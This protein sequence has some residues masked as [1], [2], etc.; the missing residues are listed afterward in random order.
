MQVHIVISDTDSSIQKNLAQDVIN[1]VYGRGVQIKK[2]A[3]ED[4]PAVGGGVPPAPLADSPSPQ[5][6]SDGS[7]GSAS[8]GGLTLSETAGIPRELVNPAVA[9]GPANVPGGS[10][11]LDKEGLPWDARIHSDS[12][13]MNADGTWR[14]RRN[15]EKSGVD[16]AAIEAELRAIVGTTH[17]QSGGLTQ[18]QRSQYHVPGVSAEAAAAIQAGLPVM[19][20][21]QAAA[22]LAAES[23]A[24]MQRHA[25]IPTPPA[26][27]PTPPAAVATP[28]AAPAGLAPHIMLMQQI[29]RKIAT[30]ANPDGLISATDVKAVCKSLG[31]VDASGEG[32]ITKLGEH[33]AELDNFRDALNDLIVGAAA[34]QGKVAELLQ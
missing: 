12:R 13:N 3:P 6:P 16:V 1:M 15:L 20:S 21:P 18:E 11:D 32:N 7:A 10:P 27:I 25:A 26:T 29:G 23:Q 2:I 19:V 4:N 14:K 28:P 34:M 9:A 31:I 30:D 8:T 24:S 17:M 33:P 22:A 5:A